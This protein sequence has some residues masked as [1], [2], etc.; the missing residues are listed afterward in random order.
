M[1]ALK[2]LLVD[3]SP[4]VR[5]T[6]KQGL[7]QEHVDPAVIWEASTASQAIEM[8][9]QVHPDVVFLDVSIPAG[10]SPDRGPAGYLD[11]LVV[12]PPGPGD[13]ESVVR[14]M[15]GRNPRVKFVVCTGNPPDDPR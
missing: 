10:K 2:Y 12:N 4:V 7:L 1:P 5:L 6:L 3:D 9:D 15:A 11:F 13:P 8:F 14:H